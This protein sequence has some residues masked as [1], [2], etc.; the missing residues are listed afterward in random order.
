MPRNWRRGNNTKLNNRTVCIDGIEFQSAKEGNRYSELKLL[1]KAGQISELE[2]Q[3]V[4]ELI[5]AQYETV[6]T[7]EF[8]QRGEKK[9]LPKTKQICIEQSV[10]YKADFVYKENGKLVVE[11]VKGFRDPASATYAKF[12]LKRKMMLY[13][14]GI[15]IKEV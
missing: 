12:V 10:V 15:K 4:Y 14:H 1:Q 9:G 7:G 6:E 3:K 8:Y 2:M 5:P 11:D 13:F